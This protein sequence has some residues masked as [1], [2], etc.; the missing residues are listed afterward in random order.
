MPYSATPPKPAITRS[1]EVLVDLGHVAD[2]LERHARAVGSTPETARGSGSIFR[3]SI[4]DHGVAVVHQVMREREAGGAQAD[5][6][7]LAAGR[8]PRQRPAQVERIPAR[9]QA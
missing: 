9:Q 6:Q 4:A 7:H 5:D 3:P 8:R 2:R 1:S